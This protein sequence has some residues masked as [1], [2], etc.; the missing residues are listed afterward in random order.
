MEASLAERR[1]STGS[2]VAPAVSARPRYLPVG[3]PLTLLFLGFPLWWAL[4]LGGFILPLAAVPMLAWLARQHRVAAPRGF[5]IWIAFLVW[6]GGSLIMVDD[7]DKVIRFSY[8]A[9][10][11]VSATVV[12]LY[13]FNL[14]RSAFP[15]RRVVAILTTFWA[16]LVMW[17]VLG[18]VAPTFEFTSIVEAGLPGRFASNEFVS[19]L[20]H[21][22]LAQ[23]HDFL[24]YEQPRPK[25]PFTYAT[26]WG[27]AFGF[28]TPFAILAF[29]RASRPWKVAIGITAAAAVVPLVSSLDRGLWLSL[30]VGLGYAA[31]RLAIAGQAQALRVTVLMIATILG[32]VYLTPLRGL[33][34]DRFEHPHSNDRRVSL[35]EESTM[36][37][38]ESPLLGLGT[39]QPSLFNPDAPPIGTQGQ[40][41]QVLVSHGFVGAFL[42]FWWFLYQFWRTRKPRYETGF[43]C[44][45][46]I[47][48]ALVQAPFYDSLGI[49]LAI[50]M[51]AIA[52]A[53]REMSPNREVAA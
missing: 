14:P 18:V 26:N 36:R 4:G 13:V 42:F 34:T 41:W 44:H 12:L 29:K 7:P 23:I 35:Y 49:P 45:V 22:S 15:T 2:I 8:T 46:I 10:Q 3:W 25:A 47:L 38:L 9:A 24:G 53:W 27:A 40:V 32:V 52:V 51:I 6:M 16:M 30:G 20:V 33:V 37:V 11:Y 21:P 28:L 1:F 39:P 5:A 19:E 17:G 43:W 31:I 48:V 50:L